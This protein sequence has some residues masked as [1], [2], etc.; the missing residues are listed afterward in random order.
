VDA[1]GEGSNKSSAGVFKGLI[2]ITRA[3]LIIKQQMMLAQRKK[4]LNAVK[5]SLMTGDFKKAAVGI[6][7]IT[8]D[9]DETSTDLPVEDFAKIKKRLLRHT[10]CIVRV[11]VL[12]AW[13]LVSRDDNS[14]S[15]PYVKIVL[16]DK[17]FGDS[18]N[19]QDDKATVNFCQV[20]DINTTLPGASILKI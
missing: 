2:R 7:K 10:E 14:L 8:H 16:C 18:D 1:A 12:D 17:S 19:A 3:D 13:E 6:A 15:D 9:D 4:K 11:Y 5:K 20:F